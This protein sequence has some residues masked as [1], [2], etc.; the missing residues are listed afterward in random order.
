LLLCFLQDA[1]AYNM[2]QAWYKILAQQAPYAAPP[3]RRVETAMNLPSFIEVLKFQDVVE[4]AAKE[5]LRSDEGEDRTVDKGRMYRAL[6]AHY[7]MHA[8]LF[9]LMFGY[10]A[11]PRL[12][13][14]RTCIHPDYVG[15]ASC[16]DPDCRCVGDRS[17]SVVTVCTR[18]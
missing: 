7:S 8:A 3:S 18:L 12:S 1:N 14:I 16:T 4:H 11:P 2:L 10:T 6:T 5:A 17:T 15:V 13:A 9:G